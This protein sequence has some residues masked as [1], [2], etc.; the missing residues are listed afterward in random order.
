M[1]GAGLLLRRYLRRNRYRR[2]ALR[3]LRILAANRAEHSTREVLEQIAILLRRVAI[4]T[5]GRAA[6]APL[7]GAS[8]LKFLD[9]RGGTD[10]FT[11]GPGRVL[12]E[13]HYRPTVEVDLDR[14]LPLVEQWI[15]RSRPC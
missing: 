9:R 12:G 4:Q 14:L 6:V 1:A 2:A 8:W 7:V 3:A 13:G 5:C 11:A 10:Q 15:R